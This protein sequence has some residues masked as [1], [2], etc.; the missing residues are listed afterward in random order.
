M[1]STYHLRFIVEHQVSPSWCRN[2]ASRSLRHHPFPSKVVAMAELW[3]RL[4]N[5]PSAAGYTQ[6]MCRT[7][8][9][10]VEG[11]RQVVANYWLQ[12]SDLQVSAG[13]IDWCF[14]HLPST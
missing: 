9:L 14:L 2:A 1:P 12:G 3:L 4:N 13:N 7:S 6:S 5:R 8:Q 11:A 10:L